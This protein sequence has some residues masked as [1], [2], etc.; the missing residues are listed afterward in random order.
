MIARSLTAAL[1]LAAAV[2][3]PR[4]AAA[5]GRPWTLKDALQVEVIDDVQLAPGGGVAL[6]AVARGDVARNTFA[7]AY[8]LVDLASGKMT[9]LPERLQNPRWSPSG[10]AIAWQQR[11]RTGA[12]AIVLTNA[13][14]GAERT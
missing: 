3:T 1:G 9:A 7:R 14:G 4:A 10:T 13:R 6:I 8:Q 5:Q 11:A 12:A 2:V